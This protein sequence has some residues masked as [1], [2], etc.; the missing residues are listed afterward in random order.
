MKEIR[1]IIRPDAVH[2]VLSA[3]HSCAHFPGATLAT[4]E[5]QNRG[6]GPGGAYVATEDALDLRAMRQLTVFCADDAYDHLVSVIQS[7][8]H[9]GNVGDGIVVV[10]EVVRVVRIRSGEEQQDAV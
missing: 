2:R 8:A 7:A 5:G 3:L 9:T 10:A 6:R 1:A 4:C